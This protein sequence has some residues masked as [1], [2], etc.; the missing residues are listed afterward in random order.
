VSNCLHSRPYQSDVGAVERA[1]CLRVLTYA[2]Y[3]DVFWF[4]SVEMPRACVR[5]RVCV[6]YFDARFLEGVK[7]WVVPSVLY[8]LPTV[9]HCTACVRIQ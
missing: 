7:G 5:V 2:L 6:C 9:L 4:C 1:A 3:L 8:T